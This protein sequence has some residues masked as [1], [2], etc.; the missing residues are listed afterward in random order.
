MGQSIEGGPDIAR[1]EAF[2]A[3][4][5]A[6]SGTGRLVLERRT[7][8]GV[9]RSQLAVQDADKLAR[10]A[11]KIPDVSFSPSRFLG[12]PLLL[13]FE[14][15][16]CIHVQVPVTPLN[17][18]RLY[19]LVE[20]K[21][22]P[23]PSVVTTDGERL[24]FFW[25]LVRP[26]VRQEYFKVFLMQNGLLELVQELHPYRDS[27]SIGSLTRLPGTVNSTTNGYVS[28]IAFADSTVPNSVA[29]RVLLQRYGIADHER[30]KLH[31]R[32]ITELLALMHHRLLVRG[33][34][35]DWLVFFAA[36]LCHFC[37]REQLFRELCAIAVSLEGR[38]WN[39]I[40]QEY[41][42]FIRSISE[43]AEQGFIEN[44]SID[45]PDWFCLVAGKLRVTDD[46]IHQLGLGVLTGDAGL[47]PA[48]DTTRL[49]P[50]GETNFVPVER[51]FLRAVA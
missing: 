40:A 44:I 38:K 12:L 26:I 4:F 37:P 28:V 25:F 41:G 36:S 42:S 11:C 34:V 20:G 43:T 19:N 22:F 50:V 3:R 51:L 46:E 7:A 15:V 29:E 6:T 45:R 8:N 10:V 47:C 31:S 30:L 1:P 14:G 33:P 49:L 18:R 21:G 17:K 5:H 32:A 13:N 35:K 23:V 24:S 9:C 48:L 27:L 16:S 2:L 39:Q